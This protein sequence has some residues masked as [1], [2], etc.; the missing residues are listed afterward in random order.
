MK[1]LLYLLIAFLPFLTSCNLETSD[2]GDFDGYWH[3]VGVDMLTNAKHKDLSQQRIFWAVQFHLI[4]LR[5]AD[6][7]DEGGNGREYYEQ[8]KLEQSQLT[9]SNPHEKDR[10]AGDPIITEE[11]L[12]EIRPYGIN[13]LT[14]HFDVLRLNKDEMVLKSSTLQL[15]FRKQ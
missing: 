15:Q 11:R 6:R 4:Q 13:A 3:L 1:K 8:F 2:N 10:E 9:L 5:G 14:E 7:K 12:G